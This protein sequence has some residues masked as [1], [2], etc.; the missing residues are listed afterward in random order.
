MTAA[1]I[2]FMAL[3]AA[4]PALAPL[5]AQA[6]DAPACEAA[7][8]AYR[9]AAVAVAREAPNVSTALVARAGLIDEEAAARIACEKLP[10]L[11][12]YIDMTKEDLD[13]TL[14]AAI[15]ACKAAM[16]AAAPHVKSAMSKLKDPAMANKV[17]D[18]LLASRKAAEEPC[19]DYLGVLSRLLRAEN[20]MIGVGG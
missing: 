16:D 4:L 6:Q 10:Q 20:V 7:I 11:S 17:L 15:P 13:L 18:L 12:P 8:T 1:R 14:G 19:K 5:S 3:L 9:Q 2:S